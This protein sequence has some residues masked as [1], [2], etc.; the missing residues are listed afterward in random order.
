MK[1]IVLAT[2]A[3]LAACRIAAVQP[4]QNQKRMTPQQRTEQRIERMDA[5]L[6]L[7]D[8]QKEQIRMFCAEFNARKLAPEERK[9][10]LAELNE[11]IASVLTAEQETIYRKMQK[12]AAAR[13]KA[14]KKKDKPEYSHVEIRSGFSFPGNV[15]RRVVRLRLRRS[16]GGDNPSGASISNSGSFG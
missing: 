12:E 2:L 10:A 7:T 14:E 1:K 4:A 11:Q 6:K 9:K 8:E 3:V 16:R 5:K 15:C 13:R